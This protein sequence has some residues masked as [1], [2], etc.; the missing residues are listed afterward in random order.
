[1]VCV[2]STGRPLDPA[3]VARLADAAEVRIR[4]RVVNLQPDAQLFDLTEEGVYCPFALVNRL[5]PRLLDSPLEFLDDDI[6]AF[7]AQQPALTMREDTHDL[8]PGIDELFAPVSEALDTD[9][10]RDLVAE[11]V[12]D[13][14]DPH[15]VAR[16]W[17]VDAGLAEEPAGA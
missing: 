9:T 7:V 6:G 12:D 1:V 3:G 14:A 8:A 10:L 5:D 17:L 15:D 16:K 2:A 4:P 13:R 11:V